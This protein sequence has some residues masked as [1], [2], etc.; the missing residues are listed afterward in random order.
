M[1]NSIWRV[2]LVILTTHAIAGCTV[3]RIEDRDGSVRL[4]KSL[5]F[6]R[7]EP[8]TSNAVIRVT[9]IGFHSAFGV[10][11]IGFG[12]TEAASLAPGACQL[13]VWNA[14]PETVDALRELL[15][16]DTALCNFEPKNIAARK[17]P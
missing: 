3:V 9:S 17:S 15:G 8:A 12:R 7:L 1:V 16:D 10:T 2:L 11:S 6:V 4:Q 13:V 5:G 14:S